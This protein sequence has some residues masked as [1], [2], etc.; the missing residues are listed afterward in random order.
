LKEKRLNK[1]MNQLQD[2]SME[3]L[4]NAS[5]SMFDAYK[6]D[7]KSA[8]EVLR[9]EAKDSGNGW[10]KENLEASADFLEDEVL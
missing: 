2:P 4:E 3:D 7:V 8:I 10:V 5:P 9:K 6:G 1:T